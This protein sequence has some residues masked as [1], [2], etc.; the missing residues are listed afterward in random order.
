MEAGDGHSQI[1]NEHDITPDDLRGILADYFYVLRENADRVDFVAPDIGRRAREFCK[2]N[3]AF[4]QRFGDVTAARAVVSGI[5]RQVRA[6]FM[7]DCGDTTVRT[8]FARL[9][10]GDRVWFE[11]TLAGVSCKLALG[12]PK[13]LPMD[14]LRPFTET[15]VLWVNSHDRRGAFG[16]GLAVPAAKVVVPQEPVAAPSIPMPV[17]EPLSSGNVSSSTRKRLRPW[18]VAAV[19]AF[20]AVLIYFFGLGGQP[21]SPAYAQ[22]EGHNPTRNEPSVTADPSEK[23]GGTSA[24]TSTEKIAWEHARKAV[25]ALDEVVDET[26]AQIREAEKKRNDLA[27][28]AETIRLLV[29]EKPS[30]GGDD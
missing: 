22:T 14:A 24:G 15:G 17:A 18:A 4:V 6:D 20:G 8:R 10:A 21:N 9:A 16:G 1:E 23:K 5:L 7:M 30:E 26:N 3:L 2:A 12:V 25:S 28:T 19:L 11:A 27:E 13:N 29:P